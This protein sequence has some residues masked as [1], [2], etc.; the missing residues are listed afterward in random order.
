MAPVQGSFYTLLYM[1]ILASMR[2]SSSPLL[3][4]NDT[5]FSE[6]GAGNDI[7]TNSSS[8]IGSGN[9]STVNC[10]CNVTKVLTKWLSPSKKEAGISKLT[11]ETDFLISLTDNKETFGECYD[12]YK[13]NLAYYPESQNVTKDLLQKF[14]N[15]LILH[16]RYITEVMLV[17]LKLLRLT[18][19]RE[20]HHSLH[21]IKNQ[22]E[23]NIVHLYHLLNI[24]GCSC[25]PSDCLQA[26][27]Q[28]ASLINA[29][30]DCFS[31]R[32]YP[33]NSVV[34]RIKNDADSLQKILIQLLKESPQER[35][36]HDSTHHCSYSFSS[37]KAK[38][39]FD[40]KWCHY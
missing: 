23:H 32:S 36:C 18:G 29:T 10:G 3:P 8:G 22:L 12:S 5:N 19:Q 9:N 21:F 7:A 17:E 13:V 40:N 26:D 15:G 34:R 1:I 27:K 6:L 30:K 37:I 39:T 14:Y 35:Q 16:R 33:V 28:F 24:T 4:T 20:I 11:M 38:I 2:A 25:I 31:P